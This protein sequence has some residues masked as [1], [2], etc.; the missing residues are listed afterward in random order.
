M[1]TTHEPTMVGMANGEELGHLKRCRRV[2]PDD[3]RIRRYGA[4]DGHRRHRGISAAAVSGTAGV[5]V[6]VVVCSFIGFLPGALLGNAIG[7][8][9]GFSLARRKR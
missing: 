4:Q 3:H 1:S 5:V 7:E 6:P 8:K 9:W 2:G